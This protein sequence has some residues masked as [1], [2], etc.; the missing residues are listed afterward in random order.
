[1][2]RSQPLL[3]VTWLSG[4]FWTLVQTLGD[5]LRPSMRDPLSVEKRV[6]NIALRSNSTSGVVR[7]LSE[8]FT[9]SAARNPFLV[10]RELW[11]DRAA[12]LLVISYLIFNIY[13]IT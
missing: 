2:A 8:L 10:A 1:M 12:L 4:S 5:Q 13:L 6:E 11:L 7:Q 3:V 9:P